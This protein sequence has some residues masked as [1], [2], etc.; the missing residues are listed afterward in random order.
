MNPNGRG[1]NGDLLEHAWLARFS[2]SSR[3]IFPTNFTSLHIL[4]C[5]FTDPSTSSS[6][7]FL[8]SQMIEPNVDS[9]QK[10][11]IDIISVIKNF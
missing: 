5:F 10:A 4:G 11:K 2:K 8:S 6:Y 9:K 7:Y 3:N 1:A